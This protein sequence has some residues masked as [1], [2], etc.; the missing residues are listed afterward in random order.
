MVVRAFDGTRREVRGEIDLLVQIGPHTCQVTFQIMDI[1][2]P[3][4]CL[5]G[6]PWLHS[7]GVVPSTL[8]Q[9][10]KFV[11]EGH[12][13]IVSGEE[14][15]LVSCPSS[16]PY[17]E[18]AKESLE[19]AFQSFE[20]VSISSVDSFSGQPCLSDTA[21]MVARV[22]LGNGYE[23]GMGLSKDNSGI[24]N[25]I[26]AKGNRGKFGLGY[27]PTQAYIRKSIV[28]KKSGSQGSRLRQEDEGSLPCH[29]HV[30]FFMF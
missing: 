20:V 29:L 22:M 30:Y 24:T 1:N 14:D 15:I 5:L 7:V 3:Y 26:S 18:A 10:L 16:M 2:P 25:L 13:V 9:K 8:H 28:G 4:S 6:C 27:K 23:P 21:V 11:V 19:T 12:L 17:V